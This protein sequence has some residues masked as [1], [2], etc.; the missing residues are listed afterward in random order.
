[1]RNCD[2]F[3]IINKYL[4]NSKIK[5]KQTCYSVNLTMQEKV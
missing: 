3:I 1:M 2:L 5:S 4:E